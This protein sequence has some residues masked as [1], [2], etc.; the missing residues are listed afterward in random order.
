MNKLKK[1]LNQKIT[2]RYYKLKCM[3]IVTLLSTLFLINIWPRFLN[4]VLEFP[5][6]L[7]II[8]IVLFSV[9]FFRGR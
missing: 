4:D 8:L 9:P 3:V 7:Y 1:R 5:W 6:Y 2:L